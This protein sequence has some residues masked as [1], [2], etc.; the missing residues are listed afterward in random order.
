MVVAAV[1]VA[2]V[3]VVVEQL[4]VVVAAAVADSC[5]DSGTAVGVVVGAAVA[6]VR[7]VAVDCIGFVV[8]SAAAAVGCTAAVV[9]VGTADMVG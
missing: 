3:P 9:V 6:A 5:S 2:A 4:G 7:I 1:D 8:V